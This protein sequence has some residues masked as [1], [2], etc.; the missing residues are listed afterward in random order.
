[1]NHLQGTYVRKA[2]AYITRGDRS[3][4]LVFRGPDHEGLQIPKGTVEAD[5]SADRAVRRE[6][7][8]ESGLEEFDAVSPI[9]A[10]VWTRRT[11][12]LKKYVRHFYHVR[13]DEPRDAW[14]HVVRGD[15]PERGQTF[16]FSWVDLP[17]DR[18]FALSLDDYLPRL[19]RR[20]LTV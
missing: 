1:M 5:E 8:E 7:R 20:A 6:V 15:G 16:R 2:C 11:A 14:S 13:V 9:V 10:D 4:L 12:P 3:E 19:D 17:T 18:S